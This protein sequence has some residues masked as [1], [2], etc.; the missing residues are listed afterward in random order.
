MG[1][2]RQPHVNSIFPKSYETALFALFQDHEQTKG[3]EA[4]EWGK[5]ILKVF[6]WTPEKGRAKTG[7][8]KSAAQ[9]VEE[10]IRSLFSQDPKPWK[11]SHKLR[12]KFLKDKG[13]NSLVAVEGVLFVAGTFQAKWVYVPVHI[14]SVQESIDEEGRPRNVGF[15]QDDPS[16]WSQDS[17]GLKKEKGGDL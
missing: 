13:R 14:L 15:H 9:G 4:L 8:M 3:Q 5:K 17:I 2:F 6:K 1:V 12:S 16:F 10:G 7:V 11:S